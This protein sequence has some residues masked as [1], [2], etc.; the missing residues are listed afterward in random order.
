MK[1]EKGLTAKQKETFVPYIR[2]RYIGSSSADAFDYLKSPVR[3]IRKT[4]R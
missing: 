1:L 4:F 3:L 2:T